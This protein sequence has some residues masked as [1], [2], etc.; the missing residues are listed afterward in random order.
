[1]FCADCLTAHCLAP[2]QEGG[3]DSESEMSDE[4]KPSG[5]SSEEG[6][7]EDSDEDYTSLSERSSSGGL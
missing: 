6:S 3:A 4:Y 7:A 2:Q 5:S 1:M